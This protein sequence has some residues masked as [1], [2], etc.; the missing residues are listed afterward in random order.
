M[1]QPGLPPLFETSG[2][3]TRFNH[4]HYL[5]AF[6]ATG[7]FRIWSALLFMAAWA[8]MVV[9]IQ[10]HVRLE[11]FPDPSYFDHRVRYIGFVISYRTSSA[12][13]RWHEGRRIWSSI[14]VSSRIWA[15]T[16]W[17][18][19]PDSLFKIPPTDP[20]ERRRDAARAVI[21]KVTI[22][23]LV[24][25]FGISL[26]HYLRGEEG[27][28]YEDLWPLIKHLPGYN[29]PNAIPTPVEARGPNPFSPEAEEALKTS[30]YVAPRTDQQRRSQESIRLA[31]RSVSPGSKED[32]S[33]KS[34]SAGTTLNIPTLSQQPKPTIT[35]DTADD[36]LR[37]SAPRT[38]F[39]MEEPV[40]KPA[41]NPPPPWRLREVWPFRLMIPQSVRDREAGIESAR[42][43]S[44][45]RQRARKGQISENLP[46]EITL[47]LT[48]YISAL[49]RRD[50]VDIPNRNVLINATATLTDSLTSLERILTTPIPFS[51]AAHIWTT[52]WIYC[53]LLP[54]QINVL[55]G[56]VTIPATVVISFVFLTFLTIGEE[57]ENPFGFDR[58][59]L[60][61]D[62]FN[63]IVRAEFAA[64]TSRP[65][66]P[67]EEWIFCPA[68]TSLF[69]ENGT[70]S[71][72]IQLETQGL[73]AVRQALATQGGA[74]VDDW[75]ESKA[76]AAMLSPIGGGLGVRK[77]DVSQTR[78]K[79]KV[80]LEAEE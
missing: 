9:C 19:T 7:F 66:P 45:A 73:R 55:W 72:A 46:L 59:D 29:L 30:P 76:D 18:S 27:V 77:R 32:L 12:Y 1:I 79:E 80:G 70:S 20:E 63:N 54:F 21:E 24:Q 78:N 38:A 39:A 22:L 15:R 26:K 3:K 71:S 41:R 6:L 53:L 8:T 40:L 49:G 42:D 60:D 67:P 47:Y 56:W 52:A 16:V 65:M 51:Y 10:K 2:K 62:L 50:S 23:N 11:T 69:G 48:S 75:E 4:H 33:S 5:N 61:L 68:N 58:N 34:R 64:I 57:I 35:V 74:S 28:A 43:R 44:A 37:S 36:T 31:D 17:I 25:A 13:D 14:V